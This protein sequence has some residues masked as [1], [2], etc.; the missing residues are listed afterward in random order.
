M[1]YQMQVD[2]ARRGFRSAVLAI[3]LVAM[4]GCSID[5]ED[6]LAQVLA[7]SVGDGPVV[8]ARV[9]ITDADGAV[10]TETVSDITA[11]YAVD[12]PAGQ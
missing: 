5:V 6:P 11:N 8:D 3:F 10:V 12:V 1:Q 9:T 4:G 7:G 2:P